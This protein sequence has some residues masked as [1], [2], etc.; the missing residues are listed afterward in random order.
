MLHLLLLLPQLGLEPVL[1]RLPGP[2]PPGERAP[3]RSKNLFPAALGSL[4]NSDFNRFHILAVDHNI[5]VLPFWQE[6]VVRFF[7]IWLLKSW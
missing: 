4:I 2:P 7:F 6:I 3:L 5:T 1:P